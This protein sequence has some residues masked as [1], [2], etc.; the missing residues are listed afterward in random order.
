MGIPE[1][2]M[3]EA[4]NNLGKDLSLTQRSNNCGETVLCETYPDRSIKVFDVYPYGMTLYR[5][6]EEGSSARKLFG[7]TEWIRW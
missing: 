6:D 2:G 1:E 3:Q 4:M 7:E 5:F